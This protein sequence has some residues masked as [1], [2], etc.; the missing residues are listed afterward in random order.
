MKSSIIVSVVVIVLAAFY[1]KSMMSHDDIADIEKMGSGMATESTD[2]KT[3]PVDAV[4]AD[5]KSVEA[6]P[7]DAKPVETAPADAP[8][9]GIKPVE[10]AAE[11]EGKTEDQT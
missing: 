5:A 9:D 11:P 10:E 7:A 2:K 8:Q 6:A 4:A 3:Q 1:L